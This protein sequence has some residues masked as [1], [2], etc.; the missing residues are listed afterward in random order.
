VICYGVKN[1][2]T[3]K[4]WFLHFHIHVNV[5]VYGMRNRFFSPSQIRENYRQQ[6]KAMKNFS[7]YVAR[8]S[9]Y[10]LLKVCVWL[11][12]END[13]KLGEIWIFFS[14]LKE[15]LL[16]IFYEI[17]LLLFGYFILNIVRDILWDFLFFVGCN[18]FEHKT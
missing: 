10:S 12:Q 7:E 2:S 4:L 16:W 14:N 17:I 3:I 9:N 13:V 11:L 1:F 5:F 18:F 8:T 6:E 15:T